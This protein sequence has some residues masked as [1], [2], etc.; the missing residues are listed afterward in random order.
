[1]KRDPSRA[2]HQ[3]GPRIPV[4]ENSELRDDVAALL[5]QI[6]PAGREPART[7][8]VLARQPD[9]LAPFL[10]WAAA[11]ALQGVLAHRDHE[12]L[13]LRAAWRCGSDFEWA[14]H[15]EYAR[16][17]G[18]DDIDIAAVAQTSVTSWA[19]REAA[20]LQ[21]ADELIVGADV[22]DS[23]W[24]ELTAHFDP[25]AL[26]EIVFVVGQ[27]TMLSMVANAAGI[28]A[29]EGAERIP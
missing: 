20:L 14:E 11:L 16:A 25:P 2:S 26:V 15:V 4:P 17:A 12:L 23:T 13:A 28:D 29:P 18:L 5:P 1:M 9:L 19:G 10:G 6:A 3:H 24:Q 21:A 8:A 7:M 27:Y 22:S